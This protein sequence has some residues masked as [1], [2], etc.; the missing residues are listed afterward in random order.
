[1]PIKRSQR[2][3]SGILFP[4]TKKTEDKQPSM[5]GTAKIGGVDY[6]VAGWTKTDKNGGKFI[7]LSFQREDEART[8][9]SRPTVKE[10]MDDDIPF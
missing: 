6:N 4:N 2:D 1:M 7:T 8:Y 5:R 9:T 10:Q 3:S